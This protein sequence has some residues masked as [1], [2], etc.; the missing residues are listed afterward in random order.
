MSSSRPL[1]PLN[2]GNCDAMAST[3]D[4]LGFPSGVGVASSTVRLTNPDIPH[5]DSLA[6]EDDTQGYPPGLSQ[7]SVAADHRDNQ[8]RLLSTSP[9]PWITDDIRKEILVSTNYIL[10]SSQKKISHD[11][12]LTP[13]LKMRAAYEFMT[14]VE[15]MKTAQAMILAMEDMK[16]NCFAEWE[17][18]TSKPV[19]IDG[20][21]STTTTTRRLKLHRTTNPDVG[22]HLRTCLC[23][24]GSVHC[25]VQS[26]T[27]RGRKRCRTPVGARSSVPSLCEQTSVTNT[28]CRSPSLRDVSEK[29]SKRR[30]VDIQLESEEQS[31][32]TPTESRTLPSNSNT[33][34][35]N[36]GHSRVRSPTQSSCTSTTA[37]GKK[38]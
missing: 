2:A 29:C 15:E 35:G 16:E 8:D 5:L 14:E 21:T 28:R 34:K 12:S 11:D 1:S 4:P 26:S 22:L 19:R 13:L 23:R 17:T 37:N 32:A 24:T 30:K 18:T 31:Q 33:T 36:G 20:A 25:Q 10:Q 7:E 27:M 6:M 38:Q 9:D 3:V